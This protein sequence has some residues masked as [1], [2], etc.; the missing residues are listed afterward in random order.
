MSPIPAVM[1]F[2]PK[3]CANVAKITKMQELKLENEI[4]LG[5]NVFLKF[6]QMGLS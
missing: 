1:L 5:T 6:V 3:N 4:L 2:F